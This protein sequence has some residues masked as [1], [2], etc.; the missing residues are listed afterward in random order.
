VIPINAHWSR[1]AESMSCKSV[2]FVFILF[3]FITAYADCKTYYVPDD[4]STIQAA[5]A[6]PDVFAGDTI[7]VRPGVYRETIDFLGKT[8]ILKSEQGPERTILDGM[9]DF[10]SVVKFQNQEGPECL[11][12]GFTITNGCA[13]QNGGIYCRMSSP[14]IIGNVIRG[15]RSETRGGSDQELGGGILCRCFS[16]PLISNNKIAENQ[17]QGIWWKGSRAEEGRGGGIY[18]GYRCDAFIINN[19]ILHNAAGGSSIGRGSGIYSYNA[20][21]IITNNTILFN[22][23]PHPA[24]HHYAVWASGTRVPTITN[25]IIRS[26]GGVLGPMSMSVTYSNISPLYSGIGNIDEDPR[27]VDRHQDW[28]LTSN[29]PCRNSGDN[30]ALGFPAIDFEDD[31]RVSEDTVD[32]GCDEFHAHLYY[33]KDPA[34]SLRIIGEPKAA[35]IFVLLGSGVRD[36]PVK[37]PYG[38]L[39]LERPI[40]NLVLHSG[41]PDSGSIVINVEAPGFFQPGEEYPLQALIGSTSGPD[42]VLTNLLL[43]AEYK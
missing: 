40:K 23:C 9:Q 22:K 17:A 38:A 18:L 24:S 36:V 2:I 42:S 26:P 43:V 5:I 21:P 8:L 13:D 30:N 7:I 10:D 31:P 4:Y 41:I 25:C 39:Y 14:T 19:L 1:G 11:L 20:S 28:H 34:H 6:E 27:F 33:L 35:P 12:E 3:F 29:S 32:I 37:T 16:S 15:N